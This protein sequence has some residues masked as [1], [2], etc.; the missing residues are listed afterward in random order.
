MDIHAKLFGRDDGEQMRVGRMVFRFKMTAADTAGAYTVLEAV[1]PPDSGSGLHRHWSYDEAALIVDGQ[2]ECHLDGAPKTIGAGESVYWPRGALHKFRSL[3]PGDGRIVFICSP[4][5]I[6]E[7][8]V[9]EIAKS[10]VETGSAVSGPAVNFRTIA[11]Q[12]GIEFVD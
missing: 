5:K 10:R 3:G 11:A 8:F 9:G 6:F 12:H 2:F 7:D 4:G 1:V